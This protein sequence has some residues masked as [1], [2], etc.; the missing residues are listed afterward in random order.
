MINGLW[1]MV[2]GLWFMVFGLWFMNCGL[3]NEFEG[4]GF[5]ATNLRFER[6]AMTTR[7]ASLL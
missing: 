6:T 1:F 5:R 7:E 3:S 2:Y 4:F